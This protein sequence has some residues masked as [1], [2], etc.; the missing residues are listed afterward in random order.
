MRVNCCKFIF[1]GLIISALQIKAQITIGNLD[2]MTTGLK[3]IQFVQ[4]SMPQGSLF[5]RNDSIDFNSDGQFDAFFEVNVSS[6]ADNQGGYIS[7]AS[8]HPGFEFRINN[9]NEVDRL[10]EGDI[11]APGDN[12]SGESGLILV[13]AVAM[14]NYQEFG[15]WVGSPNGFA[16][17]RVI[18]EQ[19]TFYGWMR[20][21]ASINVNQA[22]C[23]FKVFSGWAIQTEPNNHVNNNPPGSFIIAGDTTG[24]VPGNQFIQLTQGPI[25][26]G[27]LGGTYDSL[28]LNNDGLFDVIFYTTICNDFD[29][30][31]SA[32][33]V[34]GL[35][36]D[37]TFINGN[38]TYSAKRLDEGDTIAVSSIWNDIG[39]YHI[40]NLITSGLG[41]NGPQDSGEW[42]N[43]YEGYLGFRL[44]TPNNDTLLGWAFIYTYSLAEEGAYIEVTRWA[45]QPD[46][47]QKP[48]VEI[49]A[50]PQKAVYCSGDTVVLTAHTAGADQMEWHRWDGITDTSD[51]ITVILPDT[52][53]VVSLIAGNAAG[54][55][56][57]SIVLEVS[58]LEITVPPVVLN[59]IQPSLP[60]TATTNIP[61]HIWWVMG[62][63]TFPYTNPPVIGAPVAVYAFAQDSYGCYAVSPPV[64]IMLDADIPA[65][66]IIFQEDEHLLIAQSS[67]PGVVFE[68]YGNGQTFSGDS[69]FVTQ[70]GLYSVV[71]TG[72]NGCTAVSSIV[73]E[74]TGTTAALPDKISIQPNPFSEY[75]LVDNQ[76]QEEISGGIIDL[77]GKALFKNIKIAAGC[78]Y[79][80]ATAQLPSG[81]YFF[82]GKQGQLTFFK[83]VIK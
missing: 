61:A 14:G 67:T 29:C 46:P 15:E 3:S 37:F 38:G 43:N 62:S 53:V 17:Y 71:A 8:L 16:G 73:I 35:H 19:D 63:D 52:S 26:F 49:T 1:I 76:S 24:L 7:M 65:V 22:G 51:I 36:N 77:T 31:A 70:S 75:L 40:G 9:P 82:M 2:N 68:W 72:L 11:I 48:F 25:P 34:A 28:D 13:K 32:T 33:Y 39:A 83:K 4:F 10:V 41:W 69:V 6:Q 12:W 60:I 20:I 81:M 78:T 54:D 80:V 27:G 58:P 23:I 30:I 64:E 42:L 55:T 47:S 59:C 5:F 57:V 74:L 44:I 56:T 21:Q 66:N 50:A 18:A 45:I 79:R